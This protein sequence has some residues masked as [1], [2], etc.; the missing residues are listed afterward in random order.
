MNVQ[1]AGYF[2]VVLIFAAFPFGRLERHQRILRG[3]E[4]VVGLEVGI[5][6]GAVGIYRGNADDGFGGT[7][8]EVVA[9]DGDRSFKLVEVAGDFGDEV[10]DAEFYRGVDGV[11]FIDFRAA[12]RGYPALGGYGGQSR[13]GKYDGG[14]GEFFHGLAFSVLDEFR[15]VL[16]GSVNRENFDLVALGPEFEGFVMILENSGLCRER[17]GEAGFLCGDQ[18]V[19]M[20]ILEAN[21]A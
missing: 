5:A 12:C 7:V 14:R 17:V 21:H 2:E 13:D 19:H 8:D 15:D 9:V 11:D 18:M 10:A 6:F 3:V 4:K 1:V 20:A 16:F